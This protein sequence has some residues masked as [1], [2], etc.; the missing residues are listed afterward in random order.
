MPLSAARAINLNCFS[1]AIAEM[2]A[3]DIFSEKPQREKIICL[4]QQFYT[5]T[6][7]QLANRSIK[8]EI[9]L[10]IILEPGNVKALSSPVD[11]DHITRSHGDNTS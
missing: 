8:A 3:Q 11:I 4:F 6:P 2:L 1:S 7:E 10:N 5:K 9:T